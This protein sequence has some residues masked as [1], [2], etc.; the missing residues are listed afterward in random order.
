V[1]NGNTWEGGDNRLFTL[2]APTQTLPP[3]F[4]NRVDNLGPLTI[5][6]AGNGE[7]T[8]SWTAGPRI[9]LQGAAGP[10]AAWLDVPD[11]LGADTINVP[12]TESVQIF[13]LVGP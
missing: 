3:L 11:S 5:A 13:R 2:A 8:L 4:F 10:G 6:G 1:A 9:R 12:M 7:L